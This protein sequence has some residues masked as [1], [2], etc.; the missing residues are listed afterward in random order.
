MNLNWKVG[1]DVGWEGGGADEE[2][3]DGG[4]RASVVIDGVD[5]GTD[6]P[7]A[8][9]S[10]FESAFSTGRRKTCT[11]VSFTKTS[12]ESSRL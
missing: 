8:S 9:R 10:I 6:R 2:E 11:L 7:R 1:P 4:G 12:L 3:D 5:A